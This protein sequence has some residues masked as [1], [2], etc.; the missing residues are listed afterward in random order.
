V[1]DHFAALGLPRRAWLDPEDIKSRHHALI[2]ASHPDKPTGDA[3]LAASLNTARA[4]LENPASRL[5]HLLE[6]EAPGFVPQKKHEPDWAV[7]ARLSNAARAAAEP[8]NQP[9][10]S[11]LARA[12]HLDK[13]R[14]LAAELDSLATLLAAKTAELEALTRSAPPPSEDPAPAAILAEA[15][16]FHLKSLATLRQSR[17]R[18][19]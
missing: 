12:L 18:T 17:E 19:Q 15:W 11:P 10:T 13:T 5:R 4:T 16:S 1:T 7:F 2:A 14:K 8:K 9:P 3:A 6:L